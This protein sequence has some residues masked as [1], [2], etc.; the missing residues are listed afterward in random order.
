MITHRSMFGLRPRIDSV[1]SEIR[2][3]VSS[4]K[5]AINYC[6]SVDG[7]RLISACRGILR[8][9]GRFQNWSVNQGLSKT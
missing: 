3:L 2:I 6:E 1:K 7:T 4:G 9:F 5:S 8:L